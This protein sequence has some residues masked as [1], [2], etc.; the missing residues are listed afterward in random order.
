LGCL[1]LSYYEQE[2]ERNAFTM[3][4]INSKLTLKN[5]AENARS[6]LVF[7]MQIENRTFGDSVTARGFQG[8]LKDNEVFGKGNSYT[9]EFWQYDSRLGKRWN[10]DPVTKPWES[11][12]AGIKSKSWGLSIKISKSEQEVF[13]ISNTSKLSSEGFDFCIE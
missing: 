9:A 6:Y 4:S 1:K 13:Y 11:P 3:Y 10:V 5:T 7:G 12:Y 8:Q 2:T